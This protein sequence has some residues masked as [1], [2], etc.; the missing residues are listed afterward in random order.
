MVTRLMLCLL[1]A[2]APLAGQAEEQPARLTD[3]GKAVRDGK[4]DVGKLYSV[5]HKEGRYHNI[6]VDVLGLEC[7][8]CHYGDT[9]LQDYLLVGKADPYPKRA[10]GR[11][12][13]TGCLGCHREGGEGSPFY[14][15]NA[16]PK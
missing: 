4:F 6:H 9:Y 1:L 10:K 15:N 12:D 16:T 14:G 7:T 11:Y 3:V 5:E 8:S 13:R 2:V